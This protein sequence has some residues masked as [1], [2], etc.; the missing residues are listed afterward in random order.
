MTI[1]ILRE[2]EFF[3]KQQNGPDFPPKGEWSQCSIVISFFETERPYEHYS[4]ASCPILLNS[5][6]RAPLTRKRRSFQPPRMYIN[7]TFLR[8]PWMNHRS[9]HVQGGA[10]EGGRIRIRKIRFEDPDPDPKLRFF[11]IRIRI[12][13]RKKQI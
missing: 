7:S 12:R 13:I 3:R 6:F 2:I 1:E 11:E 5:I 4:D 10:G 8:Y 9:K